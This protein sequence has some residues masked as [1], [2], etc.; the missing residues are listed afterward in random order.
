MKDLSECKQCSKNKGILGDLVMCQK[1]DHTA[2]IPMVKNESL[3]LMVD[4]CD[5]IIKEA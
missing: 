4:C 1:D 5:K 2:A 3:T